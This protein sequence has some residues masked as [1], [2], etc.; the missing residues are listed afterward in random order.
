M[1]RSFLALGFLAA[2]VPAAQGQGCNGG[3]Y[4]GAAY[5]PGYG[6]SA[7]QGYSAPPR[8][9]PPPGYEPEDYDQGA[10]QGFAA[11]PE[12]TEW[13][14]GPDGSYFRHERPARQYEESFV[15]R[16]PPPRRYAP[17]PVVYYAAA[18]RFRAPRFRERR[19]SISLSASRA[20]C[21]Q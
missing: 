18:P 16:A 7:P 15:R 1:C 12:V 20:Y 4:R 19:L 3:A 6:Y 11:P 13:R 2:L 8:F 5:P 10:P 14:S 17:P 21:P 9:A